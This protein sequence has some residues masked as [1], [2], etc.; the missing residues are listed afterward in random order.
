MEQSRWCW[1]VIVFLMSSVA[2]AED[3]ALDE[4]YALLYSG[5]F[6]DQNNEPISGVFP[7]TFS[8]I[9]KGKKKAI[10][11][12]EHFVAVVDGVYHVTMGYEKPLPVAFLKSVVVLSVRLEGREVVRQEIEPTLVKKPTASTAAVVGDASYAERCG[13]AESLQGQSAAEFAGA[14]VE[15]RLDKHIKDSNSHGGGHGSSTAEKPAETVT[16]SLGKKTHKT[17]YAGGSGGSSFSLNCPKGYLVTG[18]EGRAGGVIDS[19]RVVC[20]RLE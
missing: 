3:S 16:L 6:I 20:T 7:L 19:L 4:T 13:D 11:S 12:E 10:W 17:N 9:P 14:D 15:L 18:V 2:L 5:E 1:V 8:L